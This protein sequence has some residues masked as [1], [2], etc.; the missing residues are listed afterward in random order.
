MKGTVADLLTIPHVR[1]VNCDAIRS[2]V[3]RRVVTD[4]RELRKGDVFVAFRGTR[5]DAHDLVADVCARGARLC[6]VENR[7][8]RK[9][10]ASNTDLPLLVV[11]DTV[12]AYGAIAR[13]HRRQFDI[14]LLAITGSNGKT[15]TKEMV[16]AVLE[17]KYR[18]LVNAGN[19]NNQIGL[20]ATLLRMNDRH[21]LIVTEM[22][23]NQPGDIPYLCAIAEPT[24]GLITNIGRA[25]M[26]KLLSREGIAAEK[27]ALYAS[28]P[29]DGTA[30][31][32]AD[33]PLLRGSVPRGRQRVT[34]GTTA[35]S[36]VRIVDVQ[37]DRKGRAT[38]KL[39][40]DRFVR[41]PIT[42]RLQAIGR[43]AAYNAAAALAVGFV[44]GC[45]VTKMKTALERIKNVDKRMQLHDAAGVTVIN[46]TYNANPDSVLAAV[47]LLQQLE[48]KGRRCV[49]LGDML[50]LGKISR[51]EH[52]AIGEALAAAG[53]PYVLTFG[54]R[55]RAI[56]TAAR[57]VAVVARHFR[58]KQPLFDA[59]DTTLQVG[60]AVLVKG[61]RS[62]HMED[63]VGHLLRRNT[64]EEDSR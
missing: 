42:L 62:M 27:G 4:S 48:V 44:F 5:V 58:A 10:A 41:R 26:E 7:W 18:V 61:S 35:R 39:T 20:P 59:L 9:H 36:D 63:V 19:F 56:S 57:S 17:T 2:R 34:Y 28:L 29:K 64:S 15:S 23:T 11:K 33:E 38:V 37:L 52:E 13:L 8:Y 1:A 21:E 3:L 6:I 32:N 49:V 46:D 22:G 30:L 16:G 24:H 14:P 55:S 54:S 53:I 47:D 45:G 12:E 43:H 60:D 31:I 40:A 25:H 50:E 51:Q